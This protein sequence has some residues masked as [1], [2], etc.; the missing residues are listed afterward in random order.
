MCWIPSRMPVE[1]RLGSFPA[2]RARIAEMRFKTPWMRSPPNYGISTAL[3]T[4]RTIQL[5]TGNGIGSKSGPRIVTTT[6]E[7]AKNIL[8]NSLEG[9]TD[10][11]FEVV[12]RL[13]NEEGRPGHR[14]EEL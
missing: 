11:E 14:S 2:A 13:V 3:V 10:R 4:I 6:S 7:R 5:T 1:A 12:S 9:S 8:E